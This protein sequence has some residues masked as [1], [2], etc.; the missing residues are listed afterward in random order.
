M[1]AHC[2][3]PSDGRRGER[4]K[5]RCSPS[6]K[7]PAGETWEIA[8]AI[9]TGFTGFLT[10][11][12]VL[13]VQPELRFEGTARS[14]LADGSETRFPYYGVAVLWDGR[15]RCVEA[16]GAD[17]APLV[18]MRLL[19]GRSLH[20]EVQDGGRVVIEPTARG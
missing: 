2:G 17:T 19:D 8:A 6:L 18:G 7:G 10:A 11:N 3:I 16:D 9:D 13:V 14:T 12:P 1:A 5:R 20:V 15:T 4:P